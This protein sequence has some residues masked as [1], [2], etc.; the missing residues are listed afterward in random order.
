VHGG[1]TRTR[2]WRWRRRWLR[3]RRRSLRWRRRS[4]RWRRRSLRWRRRSLRT[5]HGARASM[6]TRLRPRRR[7]THSG[8]WPGLHAVAQP[9]RG[10]AHA[11]T[12]PTSPNSVLSGPNQARG[13]PLQHASTSRPANAASARAD[14]VALARE[15]RDAAQ[16]CGNYVLLLTQKNSSQCSLFSSRQTA[17]G[18][19][20][21]DHRCEC[22]PVPS[23][24]LDVPTL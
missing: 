19:V 20:A 1:A 10:G 6:V 12:W 22:T 5:K 9:A 16:P 15:E 3:W 24:T 17:H 18:R 13:G 8:V 7:S 4:L 14:E 11:A 23:H 21:L 2:R